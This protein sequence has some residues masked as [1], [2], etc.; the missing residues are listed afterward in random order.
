VGDKLIICNQTVMARG[1]P[2]GGRRI[3]RMIERLPQR[4]VR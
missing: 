1:G 2:Q 4:C 3:E